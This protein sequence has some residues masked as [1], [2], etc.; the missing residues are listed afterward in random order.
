MKTIMLSLVV[1][2]FS[3]YPAFSNT[4]KITT[5]DGVE[6][7]VTIKGSGVPCLYLH[8]GPGSGSYWLEKFIGD[9]LEKYFQMIYLDQRGVARSSS[10]ADQNYS[11]QRMVQDFEEVR[12]TLGIDQ[13]L[14]MGHSFGGLLQMGYSRQHPEAILG[15]MMINAALDMADCFLKS[16]CPKAVEFLGKNDTGFCNDETNPILERWGNLIQEVNQ[17]GVFWKMGYSDPASMEIMNASFGEIPN[18]N[19]DMGSRA[20][21]VEDYWKDFRPYSAQM[22]MPVLFFYG[23]TD[24][25]I[26]PDHY[27]GAEFP[28]IL[29]WASQVGH[30]PFMEN[31]QDLLKAIRRYKELYNL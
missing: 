11:M 2:V 18:W 29:L 23:I 17:H 6:L 26:G 27:Q 15:M 21:E 20:M 5:S 25:M 22:Q 13:W 7:H 9:S 1:F 31:Q 3:Q 8:G 12:V 4:K 30:M 14:T 16:W 24:W 10:A 19:W 28:E